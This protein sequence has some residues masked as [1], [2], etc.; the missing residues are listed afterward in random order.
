[1]NGN[2]KLMPLMIVVLSLAA[3]A[4]AGS[5]WAKRDKNMRDLFIDD[6]ARKIGDVLT[7]KIIEDSKIDNKAKRDLQKDVDK[8]ITF[9]GQVGNLFDM[10]DLGTTASSSNKLNGKADYKDERSFED[11]MTVVVVDILPN[12]N[13]VVM[14]TR[15][16]NIAGDMQTIEVSGIIRPSDIS[17]DNTVASNRVANFKIVTK[18]SGVAAPYTRGGWLGTL[19]DMLWPF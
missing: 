13:L 17:F 8:S 12:R 18:H 1:M 5:I 14:G 6:V 3:S 4:Q 10:G 2:I 11:S 15:D 9:D 16:R 19:F 7:V